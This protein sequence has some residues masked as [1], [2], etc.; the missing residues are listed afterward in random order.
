[1]TLQGDAAN[2]ASTTAARH[3][4]LH[5]SADDESVALAAPQRMRISAGRYPLKPGGVT[6]VPAACIDLPRKTP[7]RTDL[8][9]AGTPNL[10]IVKQTAKG[11]V[12]KT[13]TPG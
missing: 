9:R 8:F 12:K 13:L 7:V 5:D 10:F 11:A 3:A 2:T 4:W 6:R 1:M